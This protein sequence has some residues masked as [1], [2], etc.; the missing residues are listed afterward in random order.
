MHRNWLGAQVER[1]VWIPEQEGLLQRDFMSYLYCGCGRV[2][3]ELSR[4][5]KRLLIACI[6]KEHDLC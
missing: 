6:L 3:C 1:V 4:A 5:G 2:Q